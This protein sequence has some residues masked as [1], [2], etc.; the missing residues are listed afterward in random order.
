MRK[1]VKVVEE[2]EHGRN[3]IFQKDNG[4]KMTDREF[5][6]EIKDGKW[7]GAYHM[8]VINGKSTPVSNPDG[9]EGNNLD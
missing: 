2:N 8:R 4:Q 9:S 6:A 7:E 5:V 1:S 3:I